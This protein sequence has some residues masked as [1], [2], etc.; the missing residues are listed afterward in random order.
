MENLD[1]NLGEY[2]MKNFKVLLLAL[3][4]APISVFASISGD[5]DG[6]GGNGHDNL[7]YL[8]DLG[9]TTQTIIAG[10]NE[11]VTDYWSVTLDEDGFLDISF[12]TQTITA[13]NVAI[14]DFAVEYDGATSGSGIFT[15]AL[16]AGTYDFLVTGVA[17]GGFDPSNPALPAGIGGIYSVTTEFSAGDVGE[18]P[19]PA[20]VWFMGTAMLGLLTVGRRKSA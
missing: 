4:L 11:P 10:I 18:V 6:I 14:S 15:L 12:A 7:P 17:S 2:I 8:V 13:L 20:A 1:N 9:V 16:V 19:V 5:P 3:L